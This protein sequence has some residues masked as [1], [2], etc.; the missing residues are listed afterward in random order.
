MQRLTDARTDEK[1]QFKWRGRHWSRIGITFACKSASPTQR[2]RTERA[3]ERF[4]SPHPDSPMY[5]RYKRM[6]VTSTANRSFV[7]EPTLPVS[8]VGTELEVHSPWLILPT[9]SSLEHS[10]SHQLWRIVKCTMENFLFTHVTLKY[11][12]SACLIP[13]L[14]ALHLCPVH[15]TIA[16][17]YKPLLRAK[18]CRTMPNLK[19]WIL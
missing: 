11:C 13:F 19:N 4:M 18:Q 8:Q 14:H 9:L 5:W 1:E 6:Q 15:K 17:N 7:N 2:K 12:T 10:L 3:G 16:R